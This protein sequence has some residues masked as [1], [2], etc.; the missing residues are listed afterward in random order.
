MGHLALLMAFATQLY[1]I[2]QGYRRSSWVTRIANWVASLETMLLVGLGLMGLGALVLALVAYGW[3]AREYQAA[4]SLWPAALGVM[5]VQLGLQNALGG[6][7][8]AI[9]SGH[10]ARFFNGLQK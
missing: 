10:E 7:L 4:S 3:V 5:L 8:M 1:S 2:H 6:F 9:M